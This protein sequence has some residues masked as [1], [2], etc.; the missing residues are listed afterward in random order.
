[1]RSLIVIIVIIIINIILTP[2][3]Y[4]QASCDSL[5]TSTTCGQR[6]YDRCTPVCLGEG[7]A[8]YNCVSSQNS[9]CQGTLECA[10]EN[11]RCGVTTPTSPV[12]PGTRP[13]C[14]Q[15][16]TQNICGQT[17]YA[18]SCTPQCSSGRA[19]YHCVSNQNDNCQGDIY[20]QPEDSRCGAQPTPTPTP[21]PTASPTLQ[22]TAAATNNCPP[23]TSPQGGNNQSTTVCL[24]NANA[25]GNQNTNTSTSTSGASSNSTS[26]AQGGAGGTG[27]AGG[28][29]NVTVNS[30]GGGQAPAQP[31]VVLAAAPQTYQ[32]PVK[33]AGQTVY[34]LPKTGLP[35]LAWTAFT[36]VPLGG[37]LGRFGYKRYNKKE[38]AER[39]WD[40]RD[41]TLST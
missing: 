31:Q 34:E 12:P 23:G 14:N 41:S 36:L 3:V 39:I 11:S 35:S 22:T 18:G 9:N 20:C 28:S 5:A 15:V 8:G 40:K 19:Y 4:A 27:G 30:G 17:A 10:P 13:A 6:S 2:K 33:V 26:Y 37:F 25:N 21:S 16:G 38:E 29:A 7:R 32:A 1:M 24:A